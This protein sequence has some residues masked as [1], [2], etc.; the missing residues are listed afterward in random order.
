MDICRGSLG[1]S[2]ENSKLTIQPLIGLFW[3]NG[4]SFH[5]ILQQHCS[6]WTRLLHWRIWNTSSCRST[7]CLWK[8]AWGRLIK[9]NVT[10]TKNWRPNPGAEAGKV[11]LS[12]KKWVVE[13]SQVN[14]YFKPSLGW[15]LPQ[16]TYQRAK[17]QRKP[18]NVSALGRLIV[19]YCWGAEAWSV[20]V[21]LPG[22]GSGHHVLKI[23]L[24]FFAVKQIET[25]FTLGCYEIFLLVVRTWHL[26]CVWLE[27][28]KEEKKIRKKKREK[29]KKK[30]NIKY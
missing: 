13:V 16:P 23:H 15:A 14:L 10:S 20:L 3:A 26:G 18:Q 27:I 28:E 29:K 7:Q 12:L 5:H 2:T 4:W 24:C 6:S 8:G 1:S 30:E 11:L 25:F 19:D 9:G 22:W 21:W 17:L